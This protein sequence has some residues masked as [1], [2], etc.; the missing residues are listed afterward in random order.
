MPTAAPP[1]DVTC[2]V[3]FHVFPF[4]NSLERL[5]FFYTLLHLF[6]SLDFPVGLPDSPEAVK[7]VRAPETA[8]HWVGAW[9]CRDKGRAG[10]GRVVMLPGSFPFGTLTPHTTTPHTTIPHT[11][12]TQPYHS[13]KKQASRPLRSQRPGPN[14]RL[15]GLLCRQP[16]QETRQGHAPTLAVPPSST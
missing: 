3:T 16:W 1:C 9:E 11:T 15:Y 14:G 10:Q 13:S 7:G 5:E 12:P 2:G 8:A 4:V 6:R